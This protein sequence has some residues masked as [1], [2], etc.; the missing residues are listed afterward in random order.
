MEQKDFNYRFADVLLSRDL[1]LFLFV[2][3]NEPE[4]SKHEVVVGAA[5][6][7]GGATR[8]NWNANCEAVPKQSLIE[9]VVEPSSLSEMGN[10]LRNCSKFA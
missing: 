7:V 10:G 9:K 4:E 3:H 2:P 8:T 5:A 1:S 6:A